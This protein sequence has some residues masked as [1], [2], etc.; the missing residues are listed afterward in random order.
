MYVGDCIYLQSAV[1]YCV[2]VEIIR[3]RS[4]N[5]S[6][7]VAPRHLYSVVSDVEQAV[8]VM[9]GAVEVT[10]I[11][12]VTVLVVVVVVGGAVMVIVVV[13]VL[14][15]VV[16]VV[17]VWASMARGIRRIAGSIN[18]III[19]VSRLCPGDMRVGARA[20]A[21]IGAMK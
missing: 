9:V 19:R 3:G 12:E 11:V 21:A 10:V 8:V 14:V 17:I 5:V 13:V 18:A 7:R 20:R 15:N 16:V 2:V 6:V 1:T 4:V